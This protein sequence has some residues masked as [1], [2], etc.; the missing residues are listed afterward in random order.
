MGHR[1]LDELFVV[2]QEKLDLDH[3][4]WRAPIKRMGH[5]VRARVGPIQ[6]SQMGF[7]FLFFFLIIYKYINDVYLIMF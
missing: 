4:I 2:G 7:F 1:I 3:E 5:S 6:I